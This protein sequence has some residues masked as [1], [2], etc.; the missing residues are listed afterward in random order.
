MP[1]SPLRL[2]LFFLALGFLLLL[3]Q[4]GLVSIAFDKLGLSEGSAFLLLLCTLGGSLV[5][6]PLVTLESDGA[7]PAPPPQQPR[8]P[9]PWPF[10]RMQPFTGKTIVTVNVGGAV[11]PAAFSLYLIAHNPLNLLQVAIAVTAVTL[12]A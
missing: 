3:V 12:I 5:N 10:F 1:F 4:I 6:L 8:E 11:V 9:M 7:A 2:L